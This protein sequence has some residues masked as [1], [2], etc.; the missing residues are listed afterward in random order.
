[1]HAYNTNTLAH[2]IRIQL[3]YQ[4]RCNVHREL[5]KERQER[6]FEGF[7]QSS[8]AFTNLNVQEWRILNNFQKIDGSQGKGLSCQDTQTWSNTSSSCSFS[9]LS[10]SPS[11]ASKSSAFVLS[12]LS[13]FLVALAI[14]TFL[15]SSE[16]ALTWFSSRRQPESCSVKH[17]W[18]I[19]NS[20]T[21]S[22]LMNGYN[23]RHID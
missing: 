12:D 9:S 22:K 7:N 10:S 1:M 16:T 13:L 11:S 15:I 5:L 3:T 8:K 21:P 2:T 19:W 20:Q 6:S 23:A 17:K 18:E 4:H 14:I